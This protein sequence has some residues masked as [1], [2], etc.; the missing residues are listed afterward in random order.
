MDEITYSTVGNL[1]TVTSLQSPTPLWTMTSQKL[2]RGVPPVSYRSASY[3]HLHSSISQDGIL[4]EDLGIFPHH[5]LPPLALLGN[6][7]CP[8]TII[9]SNTVLFCLLLDMATRPG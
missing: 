1:Q 3:I 6:A 8:I 9:V 4:G 2:D 5:T 7:S